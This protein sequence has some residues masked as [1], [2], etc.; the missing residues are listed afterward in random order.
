MRVVYF[1]RLTSSVG[2]RGVALMGGWKTGESQDDGETPDE[3]G[4][5]FDRAKSGEQNKFPIKSETDESRFSG[6]CRRS[7]QWELEIKVSGDKVDQP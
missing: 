3:W 5:K 2:G 6:G 1:S 7:P 4:K